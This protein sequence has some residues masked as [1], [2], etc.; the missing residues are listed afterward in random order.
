M[1]Y[2]KLVYDISKIGSNKQT[3]VGQLKT[4]SKL[5]LAA[6][7]IAIATVSLGV[8]SPASTETLE[9]LASKTHYH[10]IAFARS[11]SAMLVLA[12]HH[13]LFTLT[14]DGEATRVSPIHD[15]MGFSPDPVDPS[16]YYASGHPAGG[17]NSGFLNSAGGGATWKQ[18]SP[19]VGGPVDFHQMD[20]S[21]ADPKT[22]YGSY[23]ELQVSRDGGQ[24]WAVAGTPP[25]SL[26]ALAASSLKADQL[27][28]AT[29]QG[30]YVSADAG[31]GWQ[32][33]GFAGEVVS[34]VK[35]GPDGSLFAFV[36]GRGLMKASESKPDEWTLLS[37][38]F[39]E[40]IPLHIAIDPANPNHLALTTQE[41]GVLE[42]IDGGATWAP[43]GK[44]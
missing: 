19:G 15:C 26:I 33:L 11:G 42:S 8:M 17:G 40:A 36:L 29:K 20:V 9:A 38:G 14:K 7:A 21:P 31:A 6:S 1:P 37:N 43:F 39:A 27:Y 30:L 10:G 13:S 41:N 28:A 12:S 18:L 34:T 3:N 44:S 5:A 24:S 32:P 25:T 16:S 4:I 23:G 22:I 2:G 35:V